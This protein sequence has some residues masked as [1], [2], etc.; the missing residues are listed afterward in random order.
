MGSGNL[1]VL[2]QVEGGDLLGLLNLL[3]VGLD[4]AL[5]LVNQSLHALMVLAVL[6]SSE[7]KL[8]DAPLRLAQ[9]LVDISKASGLGIKLRFKLTDPGLHLD[10]GLPASLEG[11]HLSVIGAGGGVLALGLKKLLV[12][13]QVHGELLLTAEL[14]GQTGSIPHGAG[15]LFLG[16]T[17]LV[18]HLVQVTIELVELS[19]QLPL[20]SRDGLVDVAEV[21]EAH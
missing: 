14:I 12:L 3:L 10:H 11:R 5:E 1:P 17:S 7:C 18:S 2:G 16:Q 19:L 9:V 4:L 15:S 8:L 6:I 21:G 13:L 20:G